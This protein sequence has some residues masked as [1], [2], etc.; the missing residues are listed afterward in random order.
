MVRGQGPISTIGPI[1]ALRTNGSY[2]CR[3][4]DMKMVPCRALPSR[5]A[6]CKKGAIHLG[7]QV[8]SGVE[9]ILYIL[10]GSE[11]RT[12]ERMDVLLFLK[13]A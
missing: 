4:L 5:T 13:P 6:P 12:P 9:N 1:L 2:S 7:I 11:L 3:L 10:S 8:E